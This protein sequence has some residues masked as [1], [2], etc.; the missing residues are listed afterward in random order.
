MALSLSICIPTYNRAALLGATLE[1]LAALPH[2]FREVVVADNASPDDT[3]AVVAAL[4]PRF[5]RLVYFRHAANIG[6]LPNF[7]A[8]LS[9]GTSDLLFPLSD[10]DRLL[11]DRLA[12]AVALLE[13]D[14]GC[15]AIYGGYERC[16]SADGPT[17]HRAVPQR[18][19]RYGI[20]DLDAIAETANLLTIP[21]VRR[22]AFQRHCFLDATTF[23]FM[24]LITQLLAHGVIRVLDQPL[25]RHVGHSPNSAEARVAEPWYQEFLRTDWE[26][27]AAASPGAGNF[28]TLAQ[29]TASRVLPAYLLGQVAAQANDDPMLE[30]SFL[31]R[32]L[33]YAANFPESQA[34]HRIQQWESER[35]LAAAVVRLRERLRVCAGLARIVIEHG[36]ANLPALWPA[37]AAALPGVDMLALAPDDFQRHTRRPGDFLLAERWD[38]LAGRAEP[39]F[40]QMAMLDLVASLRLPGSPRLPLLRGPTGTDHFCLD[41]QG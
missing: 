39:A 23:G 1:R 30:R 37:L 22:D 33:A 3:E 38:V 6:M 24:R 2:A 26:Q 8:A 19:G 16:A 21:L 20:A 40:D 35:L 36:R 28:V 25:Y 11:P 9:L 7:Q 13:S 27:F 10:D 14:P 12:D 18:A 17:V 5:A 31:V 32:Y 41:R 15:V 34:S 29:F 4:R